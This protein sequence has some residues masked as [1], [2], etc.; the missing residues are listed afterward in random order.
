MS[1]YRTL[2]GRPAVRLAS[3]DGNII[4]IGEKARPIPEQFV[5]QAKANGCVTAEEMANLNSLLTQPTVPTEPVKSVTEPE[6]SDPASDYTKRG[7]G[8]PPRS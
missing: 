2:P 3:T 4:I 1:L 7:P 8:R 5:L 6:P